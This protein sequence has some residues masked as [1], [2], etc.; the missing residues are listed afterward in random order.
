[1]PKIKRKENL[2]MSAAKAARHERIVKARARARTATMSKRRAKSRVCAESWCGIES[3]LKEW[4][5]FLDCKLKTFRCCAYC[6]ASYF[7]NFGKVSKSSL[8]LVDAP[9][10]YSPYALANVFIADHVGQGD[11]WWVCHLCRKYPSKNVQFS[12]FMSPSYMV[13]LFSV[14]VLHIQMLSIVDVNVHL[15]SRWNGFAHGVLENTSLLDNPLITWDSHLAGEVRPSALPTVVK[16]ILRHNITNNPL[17]RE[18][19]SVLEFPHP[20]YAVP[21]LDSAAIRRII[22]DNIKI[23][24]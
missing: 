22:A 5:S 1:M 15:L 8:F 23:A 21:I 14:N 3:V 13:A 9:A 24:S 6:G 10:A 20:K 2:F 4:T 16:H 7:E 11:K 18:Y 12:V 17:L 19:Q